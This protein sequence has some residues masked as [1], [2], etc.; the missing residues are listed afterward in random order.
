MAESF[1]GLFFRNCISYGFPAI[2]C[3]GV[4]SL[5]SEGDIAEIDL[6]EGTVTNRSTGVRC[7]GKPISKSM[8][9]ILEAGGISELLRK[10]GYLE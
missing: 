6:L 4:C 3:E 9:E 7:V 2:P 8:A 10:E 1:N 5:F